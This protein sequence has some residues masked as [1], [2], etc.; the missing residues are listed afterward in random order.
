MMAERTEE[1]PGVRI[2]PRRQRKVLRAVVIWLVIALLTLPLA[3]VIAFANFYPEQWKAHTGRNAFPAKGPDGKTDQMAWEEVEL[4]AGPVNEIPDNNSAGLSSD[5]QMMVFAR[6]TPGGKSNL[7]ISYRGEKENSFSEPELIETVNTEFNE[8]EPSITLDGKHLLFSSDRPDGY[9]GTDIWVSPRTEYGWGTPVNLGPKVNSEFNERGPMMNPA[10]DKLYLSSDRP[11]EPTVGGARRRF[12][13]DLVA[14]REATNFDIFCVDDMVLSKH[15][16]PLRDKKYRESIIAD[17]GGTPETER[18]VERALEW[19]TRNQEPDGRWAMG[20]HGGKSDQDIAGTAMTVLA[21][22]GWGARHDDDESKYQENL[23][24]ALGWL[25]AQCE[26]YKGDFSRGASQGMYGHGMA[27]IAL[28]EAYSITKDKMLLEPLKKAVKVIVDCQNREHGG[29][30]YQTTSRDGDTSVFGWQMMALHCASVAGLEVPDE[31]F[32]R[33]QKWLDRVGGG[34]HKGLYGYT[35]PSPKDAMTA[36]AMFVQQLLGAKPSDPRQVESAQYLSSYFDRRSKRRQGV[37]PNAKSQTNMYYWYY[38]FLAMYQHQGPEWKKW[39]RTVRQLLVDRQITEGPDAGAWKPGQWSAAGKIVSTAM[40]ALSLEVYYRYLPMYRLDQSDA[41]VLV[42]TFDKNLKTVWK[43]KPKR[44]TPKVF[45]DIPLQ[46]RHIE[47]IESASDE[48]SITF[49]GEGDDAHAYFAS[50]RVG[51]Y[52]GYD[53]YR[54]RVIGGL[55]QANEVNVGDPINTPA[56]EMAPVLTRGGFEMVFS[57]DRLAGDTED[58][59]LYRTELTPISDVQKALAFL[60]R[61]M[62]WLI[63]LLA[64]ILTLLALLLWWLNAENREQVGL[65][66]RCI[67]GSAGLHAI[68]LILLSLWMITAE[69][70]DAGG[71]PMEIA[72]DADSLASEKLSVNIREQ[73]AEIKFTPE[74]VRLDANRE[75]MLLPTIT[76]INVSPR[77]MARSDFHVEVTQLQVET[78]ETPTKEPQD[79]A[80]PDVAMIERVEFVTDVKLETKPEPAEKVEKTQPAEVAAAFQVTEAAPAMT[81]ST[82][83]AV[84]KPTNPAS[85]A[86]VEPSEAAFDVTEV[87]SD[88]LKDVEH[89]D[90]PKPNVTKIGKVRFGSP[91]DNLEQRAKGSRQAKAGTA[92]AAAKMALTGGAPAMTNFVGKPMGGPAA[93]ARPAARTSSGTGDVDIS[94]LYAERGRSE[95]GA[96]RLIG[97]GEFISRKTPRMTIAEVTDLAAPADRKSNYELRNPLNRNKVL[98][99]LGG[100]DETEKAI[101]LSLDWFTRTQ[102]PDGRWDGGKHQGAKGHDIAATGFA[103]LCYFGWGAKHTEKGPYQLPMTKAVNWLVSQVGQ[104]GD[105]TGG[106]SQGMYD[107]GIATMAL[108]EAYGMTKDPALLDPVRRAVSFIIKAQSKEHGGWRYKATSRDGDTSVV[109]WQVMAITSARMAGLR[110]PEDPFILSAKWFDSVAGGQHKGRYSYQGNRNPTHIMTAEAMFCQQLLGL[111]PENPRMGDSANLIKINL[112]HEGKPNYY[113]WYYGC[114]SMF[115]HQGPIWEL[116]NKQM[117]KTLLKIQV[118]KGD[119]AGSWEPKGQWANQGGRVMTTAMSTLS[120]EVYYRYLP[121]YSRPKYKPIDKDKAKDK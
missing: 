36:E 40:G 101:R 42:R 14:G 17:L 60:H 56:N 110:V 77:A 84:E 95:Q 58:T 70:V 64:G 105:L 38:G 49:S 21:Y 80:E 22:Y 10:K 33:A 85:A 45:L 111:R 5:G 35:G 16:N 32:D 9:G 6:Q 97:P 106:H 81:E 4:I 113:Y 43:P 62:W 78:K 8:T 51:G 50:N 76:P 72:V 121:M 98:K 93:P 12:W 15:A 46:A 53:I 75:P 90:I 94:P 26:K 23:K 112:P 44:I 24:K 57:S 74:F 67:M 34:E 102:E 3:G 96:P 91:D 118:R 119:H 99:R 27:T 28:A 20:K 18:A 100:S 37:L 59:L 41:T 68:V 107:Q 104:D 114:L 116:W 11:K 19:F 55:I 61:I 48:H 86:P 7:Y 13:E 31:T 52:G 2:R 25:I 66:M 30:R 103:M 88:P 79:H 29:W 92:A 54:T 83:K 1:Q 89:K 47:A 39:N 87:K 120:L 108:A 109:G 117:K 73:V 63:G 65:L 69:L 82:D 71:D 115:Q